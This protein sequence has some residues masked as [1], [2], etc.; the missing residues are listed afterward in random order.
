M[1]MRESDHGN[2]GRSGDFIIFAE[3]TRMI[4]PGKCSFHSPSP[5]QSLPFM[6]LDPLGNV[7]LQR[8]LLPQFPDKSAAAS[9]ISAKFLEGTVPLTSQFRN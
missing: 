1:N 2:R 8:K 4:E 5:R 3:T 6:R 9:R 7:N